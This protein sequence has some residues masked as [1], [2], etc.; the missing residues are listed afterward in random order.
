[1]LT[2]T[3]T[4]LRVLFDAAFGVGRQIALF[5]CCQKQQRRSFEGVIVLSTAANRM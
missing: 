5:C 3:K 4:R 1:M 2:P